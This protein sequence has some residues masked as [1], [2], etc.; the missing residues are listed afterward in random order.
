ML[1]GMMALAFLAGAFAPRAAYAAA[2]TGTNVEPATLAVSATGTATV[3][4]TLGSPLPADGKVKVTFGSGFDVSAAAGATCSTM[5]G[6]FTTSVAGQIVTIA[7]VGDGAIQGAGAETCTIGSI[8]NPVSAGT[9]GTYTI[10]T[11]NFSDVQLDI[12]AAVA[13]DTIVAG[14][15]SST[16][17]QPASTVVGT[18]NTVTISFTMVNALPANGKIVVTFGSGYNVSGAAGATCSTM[19][20][21]FLAVP[22]G[23]A[24]TIGRATGTS[25]PAGAQTCTMTGIINPVTA[26]STGVYDITTTTSTGGVINTDAAVTADV[27]YAAN[28][29]TSTVSTPVTYDI[30]VLSPVAAAAFGNNDEITITWTTANGTGS[31]G[32]VNLDYSVDGGTNWTEIV[33]GTSNDGSYT[34]M[35]PEVNAQNVLIRAEATDLVS[36]LDSDTSDAFSIGTEDSSEV[37]TDPETT[38]D[39]TTDDSSD[40]TLLPEGTFMK[41]ESWSTVYMIGADG[42]RRPFLDSQTFFTYAD[43]FDGVVDVSDDYLSNFTIGSPMLPKAGVVLVKVQSVD[44]VYALTDEVTLQWINAEDVAVE[45]YGSN[46]ADY[47]IDIPVTAWGHFTEGKHIDGPEDLEVDLDAMKTRDSLND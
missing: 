21:V 7:R 42:T 26:G 27:M 20:G 23:Q 4:F 31:V 30:L 5:D 15:L 17:V 28:S 41:G 46:W 29:G 1:L 9:T 8:T 18:T 24:V 39:A 40:E 35:A 37:I 38:D 16:N 11:T 19:D 45:I 10:Q 36:V 25:E 12:D 13:A 33:S 22:A 47:V 44:K 14:A 3:S 34:W 43:N 32:A 2:L 6:T